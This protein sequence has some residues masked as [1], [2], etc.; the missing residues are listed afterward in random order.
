MSA[1]EQFEASP[2]E[3]IRLLGLAERL[4]ACT[5]PANFAE[6]V[7]P[8]LAAIGKSNATFLMSHDERLTTPCFH[9]HGLDEKLIS[10]VKQLCTTQIET[11]ASGLKEGKKFSVPVTADDEKLAYLDMYRLSPT[12]VV[13][14]AW[15]AEPADEKRTLSTQVQALLRK[16]FEHVVERV[17]A[18]RQLLHLNTYQTVSSMLAQPLGLDEMMETTLYCCMEVASAEAASILLLDDD[19]K[20][21]FFYQVEGPTKPRLMQM[22]MPADQGVAGAVL[23][24]QQPEIINDAQHDPRLYKTF[25]SQ[26]AFTTRNMIVIPLAAGG[27]NEGVLE[28]LNK[29]NGGDFDQEELL[30]LMMIAEEIAFAI[31]NAKI[32]EYVVNSYC[33]QRQGL[34]TCKG[35]ERPLGAWTPC[36]KYRETGTWA[37][38]PP[39]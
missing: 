5:S 3:A 19:K 38:T 6:I 31:R 10:P 13:G 39:A 20:E 23:Q 27:Q 35:C 17:K 36:V 26:S 32:F 21:F 29:T 25:D 2:G 30:L 11:E 12:G 9:I 22:K 4:L 33:K 18:D 8:E 14:L 7:L 28:V 16:T 37:V 1:P 15:Q 34:A 24:S